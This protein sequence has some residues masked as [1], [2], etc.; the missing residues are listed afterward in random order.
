M[1]ARARGGR[2]NV[3]LS[4]LRRPSNKGVEEITLA[5]MDVQELVADPPKAGDKAA[6]DKAAAEKVGIVLSGS[7]NATGRQRNTLIVLFAE[8]RSAADAWLRMLQAA[9][10]GLVLSDG[11]E[12]RLSDRCAR[13]ARCT[14]ARVDV[15][16]GCRARTTRT[17]RPHA[18]TILRT[19][20]PHAPC[21]RTIL[22]THHPA[23]A[24]PARTA[25]THHL[26]AHPRR[27]FAPPLART[28]RTRY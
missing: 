25:R 1:R 28:A 10:G 17:H 15:C 5:G 11:A 6:A 2:S 7:E 3:S 13:A 21:A 27:R 16:G 12:W 24:P 20:H 22:R 19:H 23:P 26:C 9:T 8:G 18:R 14:C 4:S